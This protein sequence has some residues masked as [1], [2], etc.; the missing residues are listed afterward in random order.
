MWCIRSLRVLPSPLRTAI[1]YEP[2]LLNAIQAAKKNGGKLHVMGLTSNG[3]VHSHIT[4]LFALI[5]L[6][7]HEGLDNV[8]V[9]CYMDGRDVSPTSGVTFIQQ[10]Q[11]KIAE[12][13]LR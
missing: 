11:E 8:Y 9:H 6:A 3:G 10:L 13:K 5:E 4:H 2:R 12:L 1:L 7:K